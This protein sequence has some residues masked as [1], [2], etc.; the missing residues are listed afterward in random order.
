MKGFERLAVREHV[1]V[2][3]NSISVVKVVGP[4]QA[5]VGVDHKEI[6]I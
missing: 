6:C 1:C 2:P 5:V 4:L 3:A